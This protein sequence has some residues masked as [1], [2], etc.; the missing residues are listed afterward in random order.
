M[1]ESESATPL[2]LFKTLT[3]TEL[4]ALS[5]RTDDDGSVIFEGVLKQVTEGM[6]TSYP[7]TQLGHWLPNRYAVRYSRE[8]AAGRGVK[9]FDTGAEL[10]L[11]AVLALA[12]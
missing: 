12:S 11:D 2:I 8:E 4:G 6:L 1:S 9:K 5:V 7:R 3:N 10:D